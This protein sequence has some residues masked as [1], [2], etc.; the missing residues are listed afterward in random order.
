M[1]RKALRKVKD[2][3]MFLQRNRGTLVCDADTHPTDPRLLK[4]ELLSKY[5]TSENYYHGRP[6]VVEELLKE[7]RIADVDIALCWQ[8]PATIQYTDNENENFESLLAANQFICHL[9]ETYPEQI[10]PAGWTD[11]KALGLE[12]A[13]ELVE[14]CIGEFGFFIVKMNPAQN[15]F[16]MDDPKVL[17]IVDLIVARGAV[18]AFHFG[19]DTPYTT[20]EALKIL[21]SGNPYH[22]VMAVHMGG[23]GAGYLQAEDHYIRTRELG[24]MCPNI[25]FPLSAKRDA[26][27]ESDFISYQLAGAPFK[28]NLFCASDAPYGKL[29]WNFGG[30]RSMFNSFLHGK[31]PDP[32]LQT[33][34]GLFT[35]NDIQNYL[36]E[37][38]I[39]F[40][41]TWMTHL[42]SKYH[43][44]V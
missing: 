32:R 43:S 31:H 18:P 11:P 17:E 34:P 44:E 23:G 19:A 40:S 13:K 10:I 15:A 24:M 25:V 2:K 35:K 30:F 7:M 26:H 12:K 21:A 29:N 6:I 14:I 36:G 20:P 8:N 28:Y 27:M 1:N 38:F 4:G 33:H 3:I 9:S 22:P 42:E 39:Q 37:N 5:L 16:P 41:I